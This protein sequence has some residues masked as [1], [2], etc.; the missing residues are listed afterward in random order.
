MY[1]LFIVFIIIIVFYETNYFNNKIFREQKLKGSAKKT[2]KSKRGAIA[3]P[4]SR[5]DDFW[6]EYEYSLHET[7]LKI[8]YFLLINLKFE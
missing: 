7:G 3:L 1:F 8:Y 2:L 4:N 6:K 5:D